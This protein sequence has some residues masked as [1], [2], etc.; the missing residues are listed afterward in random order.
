MNLI[1]PS[2]LASRPTRELHALH[3]AV[4]DAL[5]STAS[6]SEERRICL[7]SLEN[8]RRALRTRSPQP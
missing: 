8:I 5:A 3:R 7:A 4:F 2:E 6:D 1:T